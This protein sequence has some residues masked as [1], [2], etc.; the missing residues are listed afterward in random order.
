MEAML[1]EIMAEMFPSLLGDT[2]VQARAAHRA[3]AEQAEINP[4]P[5]PVARNRPE[6]QA[7]ET[8]GSSGE[9]RGLPMCQGPQRKLRRGGAST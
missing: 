3:L 2:C 7:G 8:H 9:R 1:T 6:K 4:T 5:R